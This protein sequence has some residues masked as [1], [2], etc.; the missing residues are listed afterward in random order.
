MKETPNSDQP[1]VEHFTA[2]AC[3]ASMQAPPQPTDYLTSC[4]NMHITNERPSA[5]VCAEV[6][7]LV[8]R[9]WKMGSS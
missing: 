8:M 1:L 4:N 9:P 2:S 7:S 5:S 6:G 3:L